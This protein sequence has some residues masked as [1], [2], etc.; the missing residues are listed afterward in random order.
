MKSRYKISEQDSI[1]FITSTIVE[2]IPVFIS[3]NT[4]RL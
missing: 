3:E 4:L 1:Y 2:W